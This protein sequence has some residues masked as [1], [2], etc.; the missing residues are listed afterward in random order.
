MNVKKLILST[1]AYIAAFAMTTIVACSN[2]EAEAQIQTLSKKNAELS[3][4]IQ[5]LQKKLDSM[6]VKTDSLHKVLIELDLDR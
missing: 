6:K 4:E 5:G 2:P 1:T 3:E